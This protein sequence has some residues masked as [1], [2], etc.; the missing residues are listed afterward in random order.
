M[1]VLIRFRSWRDETPYKNV[2]LVS[3][4]PHQD[5]EVVLHFNTVHA[6]KAQV[7]IPLSE[8]ECIT[9]GEVL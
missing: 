9:I 4:Y 3:V 8:V 7:N 6:D 1:T 5:A 2:R